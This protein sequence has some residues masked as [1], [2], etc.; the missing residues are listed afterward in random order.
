MLELCQPD[1]GMIGKIW[2]RRRAV[3]R[4]SLSE[5]NAALAII[6]PHLNRSVRLQS[7]LAESASH[8]ADPEYRQRYSFP[9][10][11]SSL[12]VPRRVR[13]S[14]AGRLEGTD[15]LTMF[16]GISQ[17]GEQKNNSLSSRVPRRNHPGPRVR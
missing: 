4:T 2:G 11:A 15:A 5:L 14:T 6:Q 10:Y 13:R 8:R 9:C 17:I 7:G 12:P 1:A 3:R 16:A